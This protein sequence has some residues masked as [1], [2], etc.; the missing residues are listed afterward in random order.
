MADHVK[1]DILAVSKRPI[2]CSPYMLKQFVRLVMMS[3]EVPR[4]NVERGI[5]MAEMLFFAGIENKVLGVK[6]VRYTQKAYH[7]YLF[8]QAG[9]PQMFNPDAVEV[10]WLSVDPE[11]RKLGVW[12][13]L[14]TLR[15]KYV[16]SRPTFGVVRHENEVITDSTD[17]DRVG[18]PFRSVDDKNW[19][20]LIARNHDT[21]YDPEKKF[22][23]AKIS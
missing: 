4:V 12:K 3:G 10:C 18:K 19:I 7:K 2:D 16:G 21:I 14:R 20:T 15:Q 11:Y 23:Y 17:A 1:Q 5:L 8:K 22:I 6:A 13:H 9:I